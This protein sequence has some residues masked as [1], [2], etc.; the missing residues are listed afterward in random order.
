MNEFI[1]AIIP[2]LCWVLGYLFGYIVWAPMTP[3][4]QGF[5]DGLSLRIIGKFLKSDQSRNANGKK[6]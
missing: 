4:K 5:M 6:S 3:F 2:S 1:D